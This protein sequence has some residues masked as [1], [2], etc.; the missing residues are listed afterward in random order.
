MTYAE[1]K[2]LAEKI[3][4]GYVPTDEETQAAREALEP[5]YAATG[6]VVEKL[7]AALAEVVPVMVEWVNNVIPQLVNAY[8]S[9]VYFDLARIEDC[10]NRRVVHL[11]RYAKKARVRKKNINRALRI[12]GKEDKRQ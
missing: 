11:A 12:M 1:L 7:A 9:T 2:E 3:N 6:Q 10:P 8:R 4:A 5:A